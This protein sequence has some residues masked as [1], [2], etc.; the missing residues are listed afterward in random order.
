M[1]IDPSMRV[2]GLAVCIID[3]SK[4]YF[5]RY[6]NLAIWAKET[7]TWNTDFYITVEDSSMQNMTFA[8]HRGILGF[9]KINRNV[10]MNQ[11]ASRFIIDWL[12]LYGYNVHGISPEQ[13]GKKW[14]EEYAVT[15]AK[16]CKL[17]FMNVK[18]LSQ[19]EIDAFQLA[20][21]C[22]SYYSGKVN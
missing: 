16:A 10:G 22:K 15:V 5:A 17:V 11:A 19:D 13:K 18:K 7:L 1:G 6:K 3:D 4:C 2:N 12:L 8:R 20:L 9:D 14:M 21:H